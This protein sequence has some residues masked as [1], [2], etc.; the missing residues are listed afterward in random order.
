MLALCHPYAGKGNLTHCNVEAKRIQSTLHYKS[1]HALPFHKFLDSLQRMLTIYFDEKELLTERAKVKLL[2]KV[3]H[4]ALTAAIAQ[5][6]YKAN[7]GNLTFEVTANHLTAVVSQTPDYLRAWK[8]RSTNTSNQDVGS[9]RSSSR[10]GEQFGNSGRGGHHSGGRGRG[11]GHGNGTP[12]NKPKSGSNTTGYYSPAEWSKLSF[13]ERDKICKDSN[14]KGEQRWHQ[15]KHWQ[16]LSQTGYGNH[17][18]NAESTYYSDIFQQ[19]KRNSTQHS[20]WKCIWWQRRHQEETQLTGGG[21][22]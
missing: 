15:T 18:S 19:I 7:T 10:G 12:N 20:S 2:S 8:V 13:E 3:Q 21:P 17:W 1:E 9:S 4:P 16:H 6:C 5:L 11:Y 14:K 22:D